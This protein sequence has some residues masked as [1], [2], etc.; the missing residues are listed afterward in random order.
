MAK[1]V[2]LQERLNMRFLTVAYAD[3]QETYGT[4]RVSADTG[5]IALDILNVPNSVLEEL[6]ELTDPMMEL[7]DFL[8]KNRNPNNKVLGM[9]LTAS[10]NV[11]RVES[12]R[13]QGI[14]RLLA[15]DCDVDIYITSYP[16]IRRDIG[17]LQNVAFRF[18][19][20]DEAQ[21]IKNAMSVGAG[22]V[23]QI[24][25]QTRFALTGTPME[26][27]PGELWSIFDFLMPGYLLTYK[28]FKERFE[29][30]IV[31]ENDEDARKNLRLLVAPFILRRMKK[32]VLTDL[33]EKVETVME[34]EMTAEQHRLYLAHAAKLAGELDENG[35]TAQ[36][37]IELLAGLT[38]L[39]QLCCEPSL[40]L[41][42]YA[43]GSGKLEQCVELV[44]N[45]VQA[46][47][48]ILLFSQFTTMLDILK[49]RLEGEGITC[50][51]LKGDTPKEERMSLVERFNAGEADVFLISLKAGGTGL[52]LT[53]ADMV[54]HYDPWWNTAAQ[55]QP[56]RAA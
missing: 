38:R 7:V 17:Q 53:G 18:A 16:L 42:G 49:S 45:A 35:V 43:G 24:K 25:A 11:F 2:D 31:Q 26:N 12:Q 52:N 22:A 44:K 20:L 37:R 50:F 10:K 28:K 34:S 15:P 8:N 3:K 13:A 54:I 30:P 33:P 23:K 56:Y 55:N 51:V 46:D 9:M 29:A 4:N 32:D 27:H 21:Y 41:D 36:K 6:V 5:S 1:K 19:I 40:C 47:H 14:A 48:E 39:R